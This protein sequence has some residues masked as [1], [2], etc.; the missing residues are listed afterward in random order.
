[1]SNIE[2]ILNE[3]G[4]KEKYSRSS[5]GSIVID[6]PNVDEFGRY[7]S[8]LDKNKDVEELSDTS[9]LTIHDIRLSYLYKDTLIT[10]LSDNDQDLYQLVIK[11]LIESQLAKYNDDE[12]EEEEE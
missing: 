4:I 8:K 1:M 10:L 2:N 9:L 7:Y 5:D 12:E 6:I 11:P 3:L